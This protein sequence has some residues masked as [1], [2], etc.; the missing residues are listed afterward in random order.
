[1]TAA[2][3]FFLLSLISTQHVDVEIWVGVP[4]LAVC[5]CRGCHCPSVDYYS[6]CREHQQC[7]HLPVA[8]HVCVCYLLRVNMLEVM[9]SS[10]MTLSVWNICIERYAS[11]AHLPKSSQVYFI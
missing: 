2:T 9:E 6:H 10:D 4:P 7:E 1:M 11:S 5:V 3:Y 8:I